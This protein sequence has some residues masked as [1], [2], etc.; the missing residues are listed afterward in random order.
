MLFGD[1]VDRLGNLARRHRRVGST[2]PTIFWWHVVFCG[3]VIDGLGNLVA[4][5]GELVRRI[6]ICFNYGPIFDLHTRHIWQL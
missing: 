5:I 1:L 6:Q 4:G 3:D 2:G